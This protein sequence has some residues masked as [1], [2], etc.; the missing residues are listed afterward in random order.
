MQ[1]HRREHIVEFSKNTFFNR[2]G[3]S[4]NFISVKTKWSNVE[5][6]K[7][8]AN[9]NKIFKFFMKGL[10]I[11]SYAFL[12]LMGLWGCFQTMV[13]PEVKT[14]LA[15]GSGL[16]FGYLTG[17]TDYRYLLTRG[18]GEYFAFSVDNWTMNYGPFYGLFVWPSASLVLEIMYF[19]RDAWGGLNALLAILILLLIIRV[20]TLAVSL[21][22]VMSQ[23]RMQEIQPR[24]AEIK[25][26]YKDLKDMQSRRSQQ[27]EMNAIYDKYKVK[28][29]VAFEQIFITLP[30]FLIVYR[31]ITILRPLKD[32]ELFNIWNFSEVPMQEIFNNFS[33]TD[34]NTGGWVYIFFLALIIPIQILSQKL[35]QILSKKRGGHSFK[36]TSKGQSELKKTRIIQIV[37][38]VVLAFV[39]V[40]SASG[41]GLYWGLSSLF[42]IGQTLFVHWL[43][44]SRG[45]KTK[46][47]SLFF[48]EIGLN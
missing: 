34:G 32:T 29:F 18:A 45:K 47:A 37:M 9:F 16:E 26:K 21:R 12:L 27:L 46:D 23:E 25:A 38:M 44:T 24:V 15:I 31:V 17:V 41:V 4:D 7:G 30:I 11:L 22:S 35:P 13:E 14:Q 20:L 8:K 6:N 28:P 1:L 40:S 33:G 39:V 5:T 19:F 3:N 48:K 36:A 10:K 43:I 2:N 42:S